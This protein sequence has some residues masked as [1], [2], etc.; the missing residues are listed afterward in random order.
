M[1]ACSAARCLTDGQAV[2]LT[3][4]GTVNPDALWQPVTLATAHRTYAAVSTQGY[5]QGS[6]GGLTRWRPGSGTLEA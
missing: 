6:I 5:R 2:R 4:P 3:V 1:L